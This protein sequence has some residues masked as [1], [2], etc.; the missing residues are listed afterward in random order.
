MSNGTVQ[1]LLG[2]CHEALGQVAEAEKAWRAAASD[3]ESL[4]TEDGP[5]VKELAEAKLAGIRK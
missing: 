1:Y 3:A 5:L 4:L 2:L